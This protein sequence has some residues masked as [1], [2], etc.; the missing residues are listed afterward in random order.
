LRELGVERVLCLR[1]NDYLAG[2]AAED[3]VQ[4]ILVEGLGVRDLVVG[5]DFRFGRDRSGDFEFL[6]QAGVQ[7][8]FRVTNTHSVMV[9]GERVSSTRIREALSIG[10]L[11]QTEALLGRPFCMCGHVAHGDKRGRTIGFPTANIY[12][13]RHATPVQGVYAV[14]MQ[15]LT[16]GIVNGVANIGTRPTVDGTA[17]LLEV[18]LFDF[19]REIYGEHVNVC[20]VEKLRDE[21]RFESFDALKQ[22]ILLDA[23]KARTVLS[24]I[25]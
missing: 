19:N 3:F 22:Q 23:E 11:H 25:A 4:Q 15:G 7:H 20:F 9:D 17:I 1:F 6:Q 16:E 21:Q 5:D 8:G 2:L 10:D 18:H 12:L 14:R 13:Q 24:R